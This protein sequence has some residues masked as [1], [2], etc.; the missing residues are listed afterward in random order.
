MPA[1]SADTRSVRSSSTGLAFRACPEQF[2]NLRGAQPAS[3]TD[4]A[5][6]GFLGDTDPAIHIIPS[7]AAPS[8]AE[9]FPANQAGFRPG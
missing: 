9:N 2:R 5:T 6:P 4:D 3:E 8:P 1:A 7:V